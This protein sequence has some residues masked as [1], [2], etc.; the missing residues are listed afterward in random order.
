MPQFTLKGRRSTGTNIVHAEDVPVTLPELG[1]G[2]SIASIGVLTETV[3]RSQFTDGGGTSGTYQMQGAIPAGAIVLGSKVLVTAGFAGDTS[4]TL[5]IGDGS[6]AARY[7]T[8][9]PSVF[10]AAATGIQTGVPSGDKLVTTANRPTLTV[11]S[12]ADFTNV[13]A[14]TMSV[15]I[16][17]I[18]TA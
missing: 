3:S 6:A 4:A 8:G 2:N 13:S 18:A 10:A 16:Y 11:T 15:S 1:T 17:Y 7:S 5:Q 12:A 9:T 14:G